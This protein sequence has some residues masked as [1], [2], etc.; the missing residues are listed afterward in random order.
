MKDLLKLMTW[1]TK[2]LIS[3]S[4]L[5]VLRNHWKWDVLKKKFSKPNFRN[6]ARTMQEEKVWWET[7]R[8]T[9]SSDRNLISFINWVEERKIFVCHTKIKKKK[10]SKE[11]EDRNKEREFI[12]IFYNL[13]HCKTWQFFC[14]YVKWW[15]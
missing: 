4:V 9:C 11:L 7:R 10:G 12:A 1:I 3:L 2:M 13:N 5:I 14:N 8:K 15:W 6:K